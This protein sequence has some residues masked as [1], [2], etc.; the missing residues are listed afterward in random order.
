MDEYDLGNFCFRTLCNGNFDDCPLFYRNRTIFT[1]AHSEEEANEIGHFIMGKGYEGVQ[2][3]SYRYCDTMIHAAFK[4]ASRHHIDE[5]YI[6]VSYDSMVVS[7]N[8][9]GLRRKGLRY[10]EKKRVFKNSLPSNWPCDKDKFK[11]SILK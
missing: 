9:R 3:D 11:C 4:R 7:A 1:A 2:N 8:K 10:I 5:I 6:G